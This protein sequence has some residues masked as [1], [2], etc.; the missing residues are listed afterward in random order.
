MCEAAGVGLG[1]EVPT[2]LCEIVAH[3]CRP[4]LR[5]SELKSSETGSR[6]LLRTA[7][8]IKKGEVFSLDLR[9]AED[10]A[11]LGPVDRATPG[12]RCDRRCLHCD[13]GAAKVDG[14]R[15][16]VCPFC[17][18]VGGRERGYVLPPLKRRGIAGEIR[19]LLKS[20]KSESDW[21]WV[22][23]RSGC[24]AATGVAQHEVDIELG[25][26]SIAPTY[27]TLEVA[28]EGMVR[29]MAGDGVLWTPIGMLPPTAAS[30]KGAETS[31]LA[32]SR[33]TVHVQARGQGRQV[34]LST[35]EEV[36]DG[37]S[38]L[39]AIERLLGQSHWCAAAATLLLLRTDR[40][41]GHVEEYFDRRC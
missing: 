9:G 13:G 29:D 32:E 30:E 40:A 31:Q 3:S 21:P 26:N 10:T 4:N 7:R 27:L 28:C 24:Q 1:F 33:L 14:G 2:R 17:I 25:P 20:D 35:T 36:G 12:G 11:L 34:T 5:K 16:L 38:R 8:D 6:I 22:C 41:H 18:S 19:P 39:R 15:A 23:S 37:I